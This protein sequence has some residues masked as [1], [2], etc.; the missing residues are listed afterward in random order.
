MART[1]PLIKIV[2]A[3]IVLA[4]LGFLFMRSVRDVRSQPYKV[5]LERLRG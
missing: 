3:L 5:Q 1:N 4:G 2:V